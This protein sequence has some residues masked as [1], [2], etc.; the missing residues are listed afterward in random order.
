M[1]E[2][3]LLERAKDD[4][5]FLDYTCPSRKRGPTPC[6]SFPLVYQ[7]VLQI[8][9]RRGVSRTVREIVQQHYR[10][11]SHGRY[12]NFSWPDPKKKKGRGVPKI[13]S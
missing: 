5:I 12:S 3:G 2:L 9:R 7:R 8:R 4:V 6:L 1:C 13:F 11:L 10:S